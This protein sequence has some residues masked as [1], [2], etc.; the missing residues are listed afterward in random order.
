MGAAAPGGVACQ[1]RLSATGPPCTKASSQEC[2]AVLK[3]SPR[4]GFR[5]AV[6]AAPYSVLRT[7]ELR[8][9]SFQDGGA[10]TRSIWSGILCGELIV[11][12]ARLSL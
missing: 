2:A 1:A 4:P 8:A 3:A 10:R 12:P 11:R 6:R 9:A 7:L 5:D